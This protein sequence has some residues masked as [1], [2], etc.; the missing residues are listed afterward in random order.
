MVMTEEDEMS[1]LLGVLKDSAG[2]SN[3]NGEHSSCT[4]AQGIR[5]SNNAV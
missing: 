1:T 4:I 5:C 2:E 3:N